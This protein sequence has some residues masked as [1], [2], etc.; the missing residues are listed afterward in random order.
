MGNGTNKLVA[1]QIGLF[2]L[3]VF[4]AGGMVFQV[5]S[6]AEDVE[7]NAHHPVSASE[8]A[9]MKVKQDAILEDVTEIKEEQKEHSKILHEILRAVK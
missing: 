4:S 6:L 5:N 2:A 8:V 1:G 3:I 9:V 7:E